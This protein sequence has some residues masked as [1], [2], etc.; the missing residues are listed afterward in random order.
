MEE[1][2]PDRLTDGQERTVGALDL[3]YKRNYGKLVN[4]L[5]AQFGS[6]PPEPEELAQRAF[7]KLAERG[8]LTD[9]DN[10]DAFLWRTARNL[11]INERKAASVRR[12]NAD[13]IERLFFTRQGDEST[14]EN[15]LMIRE[16]LDA[17]FN[18]LRV[19]PARRRRAFILRRVEG[20]TYDDIA[21]QLG[22]SRS[23]VLK[24]VAKAIAAIDAAFEHN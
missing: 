17:V 13:D 2:P 21:R 11:I 9:I 1:I 5:R 20:L 23:A 3:L 6:G 12:R 7:L 24:H 22:I 8:S 15:V 14:A 18:L 16:Q 10:P 4:G 19:M